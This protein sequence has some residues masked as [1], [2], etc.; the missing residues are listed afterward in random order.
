MSKSAV[1]TGA[2]GFIGGHLVTY[3][4]RHGYHVRGVDIKY[5][6]FGNSDADEFMLADLRSF[7]ECRE[8]V[9]SEAEPAGR[10]APVG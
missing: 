7:E 2:G 5:P 3:L 8:A 9:N 4:R 6:D 1:V 10:I